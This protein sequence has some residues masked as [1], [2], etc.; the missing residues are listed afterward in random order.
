MKQPKHDLIARFCEGVA[1]PFGTRKRGCRWSECSQSRGAPDT[2]GAHK[3]ENNGDTHE[4]KRGGG[5]SMFR[6]D[7]LTTLT[8]TKAT[9]TKKTMHVTAHIATSQ[10]RFSKLG[11][12][13]GTHDR[14]GSGHRSGPRHVAL[15]THE[16]SRTHTPSR[17]N[18]PFHACQ[19]QR[20]ASR[21]SHAHGPSKGRGRLPDQRSPIPCHANRSRPQS[22]EE[23]NAGTHGYES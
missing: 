4:G 13:T 12:R 5:K 22:R 21:A 20:D 18:A 1:V 15:A 2:C 17:S 7:T 3:R 16:L 14:L 11:R 6:Q 9:C 19:Q 8:T 23:P 10:E